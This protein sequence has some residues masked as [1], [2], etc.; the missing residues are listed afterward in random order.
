MM[1]PKNSKPGFH[2]AANP[3]ADL[4]LTN[5]RVLTLERRHP[6]AQAVAVG[7][8]TI[9]A[10]GRA[11]GLAR[12]RGPGTRVIDCQGLTLLPGLV[13]AHCHLLAQAG[14]LTGVDC[15]PAAVGSISQGGN[16]APDRGDAPRGL[17][18]RPPL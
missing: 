11:D 8:D 3:H 6:R 1:R 12:L 9:L 2:A 18:S 17:G 15:S 5:A 4:L 13:D 10:V 16:P 14:A 7:S